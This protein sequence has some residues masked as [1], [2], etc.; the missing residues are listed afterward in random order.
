[1]LR[2]RGATSP[3]RGVGGAGGSDVTAGA[4]SLIFHPL[5]AFRIHDSVVRGEIDNRAKGIIRGK[6][7][8]EGRDRAGHSE[9]QRQCSP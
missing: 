9:S 7:W 6:I 4:P 1:M 8:V 5:M 3:I 2:W